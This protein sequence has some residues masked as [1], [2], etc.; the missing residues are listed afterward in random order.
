M[1]KIAC[2]SYSFQQLIDRGELTQFQTIEKAKELGFD[3]IELVG[4]IHDEKISESDYVQQLK[5]ELERLDFPITS[6]TFSAD[7]LNGCEGNSQAEVRRVKKMIDYAVILGAPRIRHDA[8]WGTKGKTFAQVL[9]ELATYCREIAAYGAEKGVQTTVENH[10]LFAQDS[11]RM[12]A[13]Y[14]A[15]DHPNFKLLVDMGNF[16]CVDE[17]PLDAVSRVAAFAGYAHVKDFHIKSGSQANPGAGF[18]KS[19]GGNYLRGAIIGHGEVPITQCLA[20]LK[21]QGYEGDLAIEFEGM[22]DKL[23]ALKICLE[24]LHN[25]LIV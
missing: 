14:T 18:F 16:L 5:A 4:L 9:P 15:V 11:T 7:L 22:E 13:L 3:A 17:S 6:F 25:Y 10:G 20:I 2:S 1:T 12:E 24:N 19:R 21:G 8:T 23:L